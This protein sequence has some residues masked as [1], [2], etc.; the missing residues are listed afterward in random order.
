MRGSEL[1]HEENEEQCVS[2]SQLGFRPT[3]VSLEKMWLSHT[4]SLM[5]ER[6]REQGSVKGGLKIHFPAEVL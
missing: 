3:G 6:G 2:G 4:E 1:S 5:E